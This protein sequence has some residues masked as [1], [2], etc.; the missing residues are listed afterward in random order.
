VSRPSGKAGTPPWKSNPNIVTMNR[1]AHPVGKE[2][3]NFLLAQYFPPED[4]PAHLTVDMPFCLTLVIM[5]RVSD[6]VDFTAALEARLGQSSSRPTHHE[7]SAWDVVQ[8]FCDLTPLIPDR[9]GRA[10]GPEAT[11][12]TFQKKQRDDKPSGR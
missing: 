5:P 1:Q 2:A 10:N 7:A 9:R 3:C 11:V 8:M 12:T 4:G 6:R